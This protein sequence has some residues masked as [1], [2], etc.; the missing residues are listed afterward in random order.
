MSLR[1]KPGFS[2]PDVFPLVMD[3]I[4]FYWMRA[5]HDLVHVQYSYKHALILPLMLLGTCNLLG[6]FTISF[7]SHTVK[8][9]YWTVSSFQMWSRS[10]FWT[11]ME[12]MCNIWCF[13]VGFVCGSNHWTNKSRFYR[14]VQYKPRTIQSQ[15]MAV[16]KGHEN[17]WNDIAHN[18]ATAQ[19]E[20]AIT[21]YLF[22]LSLFSG[23]LSQ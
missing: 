2:F 20:G 19:R 21:L 16:R 7:C 12:V 1:E 15:Y 6:S 9:Y 22:S 4:V 3:F 8:L 18:K 10:R 17:L 14:R 11:S 13:C 5:F 23:V